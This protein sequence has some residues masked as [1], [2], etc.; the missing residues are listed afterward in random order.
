MSKTGVLNPRG[1]KGRGEIKKNGKAFSL[2][3]PSAYRGSVHRFQ[4]QADGSEPGALHVRGV[5]MK[6]RTEEDG[7]RG[8]ERMRKGY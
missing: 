3:P 4:R 6:E 8:E 7:V 5:E 1:D 2:S